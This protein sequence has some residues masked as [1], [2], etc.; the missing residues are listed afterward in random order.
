[1]DPKKNQAVIIWLTGMSGSGKSTHSKHL[2]VFFGKYGYSIK[3]LDGDAVRKNDDKKLGFGF[4]DVRDNN[5]RIANMCLEIIDKFDYIIVP[6][7]SPYEEIRKE[8]RKILSPMF[9]LIFVKADID[10]LKARDTKGLYAAADRGEITDLIGYS[11][12][13]PYEIPSE[14]DFVIDTGGNSTIEESRRRLLE[15]INHA[16]LKN[17]T[18]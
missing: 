14:V 11:K 12:T 3:I 10:S 7:I 16:V 6:V 17:E 1:L 18:I 13:N 4:K 2:K 9:H 15:Y 5:L 8:V